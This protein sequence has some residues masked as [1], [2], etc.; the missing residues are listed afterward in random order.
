MLTEAVALATII[1]LL[2]GI[3]VARVGYLR[4]RATLRADQ[5]TGISAQVATMTTAWAE[6]V[7]NLRRANDRSIARED[8]LNEE[9][10]ALL[11]RIRNVEETN[12]THLTKLTEASHQLEE[13]HDELSEM[14][15]TLAE[16]TTASDLANARE[17]SYRDEIARLHARV[18]V[19]EDTLRAKDIPVPSHPEE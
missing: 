14:H 8:V 7:A 6:T 13:L 5:E 10:K 2:V 16:L 12:E 17:A 11:L 3:P 9:V 18:K 19:L 1:S 15:T 4:S